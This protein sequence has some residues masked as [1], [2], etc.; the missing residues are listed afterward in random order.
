MSSID[1]DRLQTDIATQGPQAALDTLAADLKQQGRYHEL[2]DTR[3]MQARHRLGLPT[4]LTGGLDAIGEPL[5]TQIE[6][7]YLVACREVGFLLLGQGKVRESWMYLRPLG[8]NAAVAEALKPIEADDD[9]FEELIDVTLNEGV[10]PVRGFGL[11]MKNYGTCNAIT[12]FESE[13]SRRGRNHQQQG[14][15]ML[16][17]HLHGELLDSLRQEIRRQ[18]GTSLTDASI[19]TIVADRDWLFLENN[20]HIDTS[21]LAAIIRF[22]RLV[23]NPEVLRLALDLTAYGR[24]LSAQYQFAG[25]EPFV[26]FY[27]THEMFFR[28]S[29]G[30]NLEAALQYF[31]DRAENANPVEHGTAPL[32]TYVVLLARHKRYAEAIDALVRLLPEGA[33]TS[34]HAPTL[35]ELSELAG[36]YRQ[37]MDT[38]RKRNDVLG[39][40]AGVI[41]ATR[42]GGSKLHDSLGNNKKHYNIAERFTFQYPIKR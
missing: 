12:T 18:E 14:A 41:E 30:E 13:L 42:A 25:E 17:R 36:D 35:L 22:A 1:F 6:D 2:F 15:E 38:A 5:R 9:N 26:E 3:L 37:L 11:V 32:E 19:A 39:F 4:I 8:D 27:K 31:R 16:V 23:E 24:C 20:Y 40:A 10:D 7:A 33:Q 28:A 21:H 34:P 29:L